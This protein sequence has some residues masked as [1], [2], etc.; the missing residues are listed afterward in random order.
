MALFDNCFSISCFH[1]SRYT[2]EAFIDWFEGS[3]HRAERA[4]AYSVGVGVP[5]DIK[6]SFEFSRKPLV[7][8][9][10]SLL[11]SLFSMPNV[12]MSE[13]FTLSQFC[14]PHSHYEIHKSIDCIKYCTFQSCDR[15]VS[16]EKRKR[17]LLMRVCEQFAHGSVSFCIN[18]QR[19][20]T[21]IIR[22]FLDIVSC[23]SKT[24]KTK[25]KM[26]FLIAFAVLIVCAAAAPGDR[27][28][29]VLAQSDEINPDGSF[30]NK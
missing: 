22:S 18:S 23:A 7:T 13:C 6:A 11:L 9:P 30:T 28:A 10:Q 29:Q 4:R 17:S 27:E 19:M 3:T 26:K 15:D 16:H 1:W 12:S 14:S 20:P 8:M 25:S 5:F 2:S 21:V 24:K